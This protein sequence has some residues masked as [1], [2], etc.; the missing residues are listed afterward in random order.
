V[1]TQTSQAGGERSD[2]TSEAS[3]V[4][5][6]PSAHIDKMSNSISNNNLTSAPIPKLIR[7]IAVPASI[8]FFFNTMFNVTDTFFAGMISSQAIAA[9]SLSFPVFFSI[10]AIG[11][12]ISTGTQ[13]LVANSIGKGDEKKAHLIGMQAISFSLFAGIVLTV[14]GLFTAPIFA[15]ILGADGEYLKMTLAY[16][17]IIFLGTI[18]FLLTFVLN[19][20]LTSR[21]DTKTIRNL[22]IVSF[23]C[24][25]LLDPW[26]I[27][28]WLGVP[29]MGISGIALG[30]I[31]IQLGGTIF[32][33]WKLSRDKV[34]NLSDFEKIWPKREIYGEILRQG[35]PASAGSITIAVGIFVITF[36]ISKFGQSAVA[37]Y[38]I[39]T[40]I[41]Q[42]VLIPNIG[43]N[44]AAITL[45]GQNFGAGMMS[46]V[47][48]VYKTSLQYGLTLITGGV[49][50]LYLFAPYFFQFFTRDAEIVKIGTEY[51]RIAAFIYWAYIILYISIATLQ[52]LKRP[53]FAMFIGL[54]RQI[55]APII[56]F[57]VL[58][59]A[60]NSGLLG[61]WWGIF[62][63]TWFAA[64]V[65]LLYIRK[66]F[67]EAE[68]GK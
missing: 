51:V 54:F 28:G 5:F 27:Y 12:G 59:Q 65:A 47:K 8:G 56:V 34:I 52:G 4:R 66:V 26:L 38:G 22:F 58:T 21:G 2:V 30:T 61:I 64:I 24:N 36:F 39:A 13:A 29:A 23:L 43:L 19:S 46:R 62:G 31:I 41:E 6:L 67:R 3:Q 49:F 1:G 32:Y 25:V 11:T 68:F 42:I 44:I 50:L 9:I 14:L 18:F 40:R 45:V 35:V 7:N 37:A 10:I 53:L 55:I 16:I 17:N 20:L 63:I 48:E 57:Y 60:Y 15:K 33:F